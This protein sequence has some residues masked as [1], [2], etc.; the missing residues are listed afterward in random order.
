[1]GRTAPV[2]VITLLGV[3]VLL[4]GFALWRVGQQPAPLPPVAVE[5]PD[6]GSIPPPRPSTR[7]QPIQAITD[8]ANFLIARQ[9]E[10]GAWR[11]DVYATFKDGTALTPFAI[12]ALQE[13]QDAGVRSPAMDAAIKK[14]I[15]W[16]AKL[17]KKDGTIDPGPDGL[18]YPLYTAA[19]AIKVYSHVSAHDFLVARDGWVKYLKERQLTEKLG[20]KPEDKQ[21]GGWGY[22]RV[23]PKKP[24]PNVIAP[25]LIESNLSATVF[26]LDA[27]KTAGELDADTAK[28][29]VK[30]VRSCHNYAAWV[31]IIIKG[32]DGGFHFIYD[33]PTRNKAGMPR[34]D[35][36]SQSWL[37]HSYGSATADGVRA[38]ALCNQSVGDDQMRP[39]AASAWLRDHFSAD[40][41]PGIYAKAH[42][43]N[44]EAVYYYYAA[45]VAKA[46]REQKTTLPDGRDW[47]DELSRELIRRQKPDGSWI[48]P[49]ELVRENDPIVATCSA[50]S[51]L[52]TC[53]PVK[54]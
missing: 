39:I 14:G 45:S 46:F 53:N 50:I 26:A 24:E 2:A 19:L 51:A 49:V 17:S 23:I 18:D 48:N 12:T 13:A 34:T 35:D 25:S 16:L 32:I 31:T 21:Y 8:G 20:W 43:P 22:C 30:F 33:D 29:A 36:G 11:S 47:A 41:H 38:L 54:R 1:M 37:F 7:R 52:A 42:E 9:S 6:D 4:G 3:S 40:T 5:A 27:L 10:D 28:A 15:H 44:R